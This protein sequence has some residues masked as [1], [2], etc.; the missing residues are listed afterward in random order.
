MSD[1]DEGPKVGQES[2]QSNGTA[3][4]ENRGEL[5]DLDKLLVKRV[6]QLSVELKMQVRVLVMHALPKGSWLEVLLRADIEHCLSV[7]ITC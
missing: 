2:G 4:I 1:G 3:S 6:L 5:N 7:L